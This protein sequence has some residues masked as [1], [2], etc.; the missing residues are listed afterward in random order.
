MPSGFLDTICE[1]DSTP[2]THFQ[3]VTLSLFFTVV[4]CAVGGLKHWVLINKIFIKY[5][6]VHVFLWTEKIDF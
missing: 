5:F 6:F 2:Y 4:F 3:R 1:Q